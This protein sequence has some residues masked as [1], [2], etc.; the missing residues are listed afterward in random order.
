MRLKEIKPSMIF[1]SAK[2]CFDPNLAEKVASSIR[3]HMAPDVRR[4][5]LPGKVTG[6][7]VER[8]INKCFHVSMVVNS[9]KAILTSSI[10]AVVNYAIEHGITQEKLNFWLNVAKVLGVPSGLTT[11]LDK[12]T[13]PVELADGSLVMMIPDSKTGASKGKTR[14]DQLDS[15]SEVRVHK[16]WYDP[17]LDFMPGSDAFGEM[18][19]LLNGIY[20]SIIAPSASRSADALHYLIALDQCGYYDDASDVAL[21]AGASQGSFLDVAKDIRVTSWNGGQTSTSSAKLLLQAPFTR[22]VTVVSEGDDVER[23]IRDDWW[24]STFMQG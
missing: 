20:K 12:T 8:Y 1:V 5:D 23:E 17:D 19:I 14:A 16:A 2:P 18:Q 22:S 4:S 24:M 3:V 10:P 21:L 6:P 15:A 7:V 11:L 13:A 9:I